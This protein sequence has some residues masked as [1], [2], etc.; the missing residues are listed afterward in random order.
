MNHEMLSFEV[1]SFNIGYNCI[2]GRPFLLKFMTLKH[3][4]YAGIM[5]PGPKGVITI[6]ADHL[7]MLAYEFASLAQASR[8]DD[9]VM[10]D[11]AT[12]SAKIQGGN[13][14]RKPAGAKPPPSSTT[15]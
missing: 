7:D 11:Q 10:Q 6:K 8:F 2:L 13:A 1:A 9:K 5:M 3:I 14:P 4:A 12:K 15:R